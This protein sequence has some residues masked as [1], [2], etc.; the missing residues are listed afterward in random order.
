MVQCSSPQARSRRRSL[1]APLIA[2]LVLA[3][4]LAAAEKGAGDRPVIPDANC[5]L[6]DDP[7]IAGR[8]D[9]LLEFLAKYCGREA[10]FIGGVESGE[11]FAGEPN[12]E[13]AA[14]DIAVSNPAQDTSGTAKT[15]SETSIAVN[16]TTGVLCSA[17]N[18]S[19]HGVTQDKGFSGFG[20]SLDNGATWTDF[21]AI[22]VANFDTGDPSLVWRKVDGK[23]YY[24]ALK[25]GGLGIYRSDDDCQSFNFVANI[26]TGSDDKEIMAVDNNDASPYYGRLY[27][28]WTDFGQG[29]SIFSTY[30]TDAGAT[31]SAQVA[32]SARRRRPG[33]L[34][35]GRAERRRLRRLGALEPL[36]VRPD[37]RRG[38]PLDQRRH[39]L[40]AGH[41]P[42][43]R[44]DQPARQRRD[45][46]LRPS[47]ARRQHPLP[48]LA[49]PSR[50][51]A[52]ARCT[53]STPYDPDAFSCGDVVNIYY[54]RSTDNGATW[55][56]EVLINDDASTSDQWL[57]SLS[58]GVGNV[59]SPSATTA[60]RTTPATTTLVR[61]LL[62]HLVRRRREL[63]DRACG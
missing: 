52:R 59:G 60:A 15:Q 62:A 3:A 12:F 42:D 20:R 58:V 18:D 37:R 47:G 19:F 22:S 46:E 36:P 35:G 32:V 21:G 53:S 23:F 55:Q 30:S 8:L 38:R 41:R 2:T 57:P 17:W 27:V 14:A 29:A 33:R 4:P 13:P 40:V 16:P 24:A 11:G 43:D 34:A 7:K 45:H 54:R 6:L 44:Q 31:W 61:L 5:A 25:D 26:A 10:E 50:S 48:A 56:T 49:A 63:A 28:V 51:T 9:G 39:E 1:Y